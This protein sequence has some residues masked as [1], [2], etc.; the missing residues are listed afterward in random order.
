[1]PELLTGSDRDFGVI[2]A[3]RAGARRLAAAALLRRVRRR[4]RSAGRQGASSDRR[5]GIP[6]CTVLLANHGRDVYAAEPLGRLSEHSIISELT[7]WRS[8]RA[9][10]LFPFRLRLEDGRPG[11]RGQG[12][13]ARPRGDCRRRG[14][15]ASV[16]SKPGAR[17][18]AVG[19]AARPRRLRTA[20]SR[21]STR[22]PIRASPRTRRHRWDRSSIQRPARSR[23][24]SND[25]RTRS[26]V[27]ASIGPTSGRRT[28]SNCALRGWPRCTR[29]GTAAPRLSRP[30]PGSATSPLAPA[31]SR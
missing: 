18:H 29:S 19:R 11:S 6:R 7:S 31:S 22:R 24:S 4:R 23:W 8:G 21:A 2:E 13:A 16:R 12:E 27:T 1:M 30:K 3:S 17:L 14:A 15:G 9:T 10:G 26:C 20:R 25:C 5:A 28:A